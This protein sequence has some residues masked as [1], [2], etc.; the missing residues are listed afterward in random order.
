M[1]E[2]AVA[3]ARASFEGVSGA[4]WAVLALA[5]VRLDAGDLAVARDLVY[6]VAH[7]ADAAEIDRLALAIADRAAAG[8]VKQQLLAAEVYEFL[9]E[10]NPSVRRVWEPLIAL[11][12]ALGD[13]DRLANV[14]SGTLPALTEISERTA[15]RLQ[16][17]HY[18]IDNLQRHHDAVEVLRDVL[19]DDPDHLEAAGLLESVLRT[20]KDDDG[21][22]DFLWQRFEDARNR[23]NPATV[24]DVAN[25]L[26][27]LL[28]GM[29]R[30]TP[31]G[32]TPRP[33][34]SLPRIA[35]CCAP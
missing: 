27:T 13:G 7:A 33:S 31:G 25:R 1:L 26:G 21:L 6:E 2:R 23:R 18:L 5:E 28:D 9:R 11:Y 12:R 22:A 4:V 29:A 24:I 15:L 17:A 16:H 14:V 32:C 30:P 34:R 19:L 35:I 20:L 8:S 3:A 10:R